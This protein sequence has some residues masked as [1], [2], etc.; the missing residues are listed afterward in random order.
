[1]RRKDFFKLGLLISTGIHFSLFV[2]FPIWKSPLPEPEIMEV[3]L[4]VV[5][6][7]RVLP[8]KIPVASPPP[9]PPPLPAPPVAP[10]PEAKVEPAEASPKLSPVELAVQTTQD[11]PVLPPHARPESELKVAFPTLSFEP[12][13]FPRTGNVISKEQME[14]KK[15]LLGAPTGTTPLTRISSP[16][17]GEIPTLI[18]SPGAGEGKD[19]IAG[20]EGPVGITFRGL[21]TRKVMY[22]PEFT[23][24]ADMEKQGREGSGVVEVDVASDGSVV[25]VRIISAAGLPQFDQEIRRKAR[26]YKFSPVD[27]PGIKT[28]PGEF[29]FRLR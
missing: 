6:P 7:E 25:D 8:E 9:P 12:V 26:Y 28:Y 19:F 10:P 13:A 17:R 16:L 27:E 18:P 1:M 22:E 20:A 3:S 14:G 15:T 24:P 4:I 11:I 21:G 23:Y 5:E 29:N 2:F